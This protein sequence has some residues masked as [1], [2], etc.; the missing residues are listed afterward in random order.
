LKDIENEAQ[1]IETVMHDGGHKNIVTVLKHGWL[2][3]SVY[4]IDMELCGSSLEAY[5]LHERPQALNLGDLASLKESK[6]DERV[7]NMWTIMSEIAAGIEYIHSKSQVHRDLKPS[8]G[9]STRPT[10][11]VL[12]RSDPSAL[13]LV[14]QGLENRRLWNNGRGHLT[15]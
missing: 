9:I 5:I 1:A 10:L 3:S 12:V 6:L 15:T 4:F 8:N 14:Q 7:L 13:F 11:S 2:D